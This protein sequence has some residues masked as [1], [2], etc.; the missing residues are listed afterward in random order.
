MKEYII[1]IAFTT[2]LSSLC[3]LLAPERWEKYIRLVTG[4]L[5]TICIARPIIGIVGGDFFEEIEPM[6]TQITQNR[7]DILNKELEAELES[8]LAMDVKERLK[9]DF[10]RECVARVRVLATDGRISGVDSIE[11]RGE[12]I[13]SVAIGRLREIYGASEVKY[14]GP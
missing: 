14:L 1:T 9:K 2:V 10:G 13:D 7:E 12:K 3:M 11:I 5:V 6:G 8:K 4:L